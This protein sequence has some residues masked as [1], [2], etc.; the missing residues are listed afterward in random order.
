MIKEMKDSVQ[1]VRIIRSGTTMRDPEAWLPAWEKLP[2]RDWENLFETYI[3]ATVIYIRAGN[4]NIL[5]DTGW[6]GFE[7]DTKRPNRL[8]ME[9]NKWQ[10]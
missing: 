6:E 9:M 2:H 4:A 3:L 8:K 10:K 5:I 7:P 1:Q